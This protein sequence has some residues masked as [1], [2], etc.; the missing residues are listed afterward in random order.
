V[1]VKAWLGHESIT[2]T[3]IYLHH[4]GSPADRAGLARLNASG[5]RGCAEGTI[6]RMTRTE[7][8]R[9][10]SVYAVNASIR[11]GAHSA[12]SRLSESNR[13]HSHYE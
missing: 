9:R 4:L 2:T 5:R 12:W 6:R 1:T 11:R 8:A 3:T 13:R 10:L 7:P